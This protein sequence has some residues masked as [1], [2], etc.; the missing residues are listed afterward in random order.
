MPVPGAVDFS[1]DDVLVSPST[2]DPH[3]FAITSSL[4]GASN[5]DPRFVNCTPGSSADLNHVDGARVSRKTTCR[6]NN[7]TVSSTSTTNSHQPVIS[8][9]QQQYEDVDALQRTTKI[10][11]YRNIENLFDFHKPA[12]HTS[13]GE[14][15]HLDFFLELFDNN[16]IEKV[17][18]ETNLYASQP[19]KMKNGKTE[20][21]K[22]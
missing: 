21:T 13:E 14:K 18:D 5:T 1:G 11:S 20:V 6:V 2:S 15:K 17:V 8:M 12:H 10:G 7:S 3:P 9:L 4:S 16:I 19:R 22:K